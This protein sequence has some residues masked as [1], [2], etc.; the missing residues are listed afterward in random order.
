MTALERCLAALV[1]RLE[2]MKFPYMVIGGLANAVWGVPRA[3]LDVDVTVWAEEERWSQLL[4]G[5]EGQFVPLVADALAFARETRV[6]PVQFG[7]GVRVDLILA[8]LP[9]EREAIHRA[10]AVSMAGTSVRVATA[11]DLILMK[12]ISRRPRDEEDVRGIL[13]RRRGELDF[14]Y[15]QPRVEELARLLEQPEFLTRWRE[16]VHTPGEES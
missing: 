16:L 14:A 9:F 13:A 6:L 11:E 12:L 4:A 15:L 7:E 1:A 3:T 10:V 5:L 2:E 8:L